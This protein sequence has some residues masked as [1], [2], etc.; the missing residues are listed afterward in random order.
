MSAIT[1]NPHASRH[2]ALMLGASLVA[3]ALAFGS[4]HLMGGSGTP[5][6]VTGA[7]VG[8]VSLLSLLP[9]LVRSPESFGTAALCASVARLLLVMFGAL[10]LTE[11]GGFPSKPVWLGVVLGAGLM[12]IV[13]TASVVTILLSIERQKAGTPGVES[14]PSC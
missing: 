8:F 3:G 2:A 9:G 7:L 1:A 10:V 13:E 5:A 4:A 14:S 6:I 11:V 12:L